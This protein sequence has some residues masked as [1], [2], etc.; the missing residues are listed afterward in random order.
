MTTKQQL[1]QLHE[2]G[3]LTIYDGTHP[4]LYLEVL[5]AR[6]GEVHNGFKG[7]KTKPKYSKRVKATASPYLKKLINQV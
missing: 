7:E 6:K 5:P 2:T 3:R 1:K 4:L